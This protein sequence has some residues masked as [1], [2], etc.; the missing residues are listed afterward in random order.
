MI[1]HY[2]QAFRATLQKIKAED[3]VYI[4]S[5]NIVVYDPDRIISEIPDN[6]LMTR[7]NV[8]DLV[9]S[10]ASLLISLPAESVI[11][12]TVTD[13]GELQ[14]GFTGYSQKLIISGTQNQ[15]I[16]DIVI[17]EN[18][19]DSDQNTLVSIDIYGHPNSTDG[20]TTQDNILII[21]F[22]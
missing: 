18:W 13:L 9:G 17:T 22:K 15:Y 7:Q 16:N 5:E 19:I 2:I 12:F 1:R 11:P 8:L 20:L 3:G 6:G 4:K 14:T 10:S 21:L